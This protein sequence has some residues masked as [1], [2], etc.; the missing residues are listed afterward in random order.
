MKKT[1]VILLAAM[2]VLILAAC[3]SGG[4]EEAS[5]EKAKTGND[6]VQ[7]FKDAGLEAE[8]VREM[9]KDDYGAA[10]MTATEG[11]RFYI[12]SL[13]E[14]NGGRIMLFENE[15]DMEAT[16]AYYDELGKT[17]AIFFSWTASK[18]NIL[19]QINGNLPEEEYNKYKAA[20][21]SL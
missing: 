17:S 21:E 19:V 3:G 5:G 14:D 9:T 1:S 6:V 15:K 20:L 18:D 4:S 7:A 13:G 10:P 11:L 16:K 8:S 2:L 12:P